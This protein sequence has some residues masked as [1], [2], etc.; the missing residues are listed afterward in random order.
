MAA[1]EGPRPRPLPRLTRPA[2]ALL[3]PWELRALPIEVSGELAS[4]VAT[5]AASNVELWGMRM[6]KGEG[7]RGRRYGA[8]QL[9]VNFPVNLVTYDNFK[10]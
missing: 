4:T 2:L 9:L 10:Y 8:V 3:L 1:A 6:G 7:G 5:T